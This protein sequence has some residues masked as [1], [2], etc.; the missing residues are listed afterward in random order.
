MDRHEKKRET[1]NSHKGLFRR[2]LVG[3]CV[4]ELVEESSSLRG[5][6]WAFA[7]KENSLWGTAQT[8][9]KPEA[10]LHLSP[11]QPLLK[12]HL[13]RHAKDVVCI[14]KTDIVKLGW[15]KSVFKCNCVHFLYTT[16]WVVSDRNCF[17]F[18][19]IC[20]NAKTSFLLWREVTRPP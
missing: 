12:K 11:P 19:R 8:Y 14:E 20:K 10:V 1:D 4:R 15:Q 5:P 16:T 13:A 9:T 18:A 7:H 17:I 3:R 6:K 2:N